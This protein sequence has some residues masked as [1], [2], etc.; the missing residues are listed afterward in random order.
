MEKLADPMMPILV[1]IH[2]EVNRPSTG[3]DDRTQFEI[4]GDANKA[5][6]TKLQNESC[7]FCCPQGREISTYCNPS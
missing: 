1:T 4:N 3:P 6:E 7:R 5:K 2:D